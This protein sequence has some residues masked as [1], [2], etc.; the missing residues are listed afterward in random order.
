[1]PYGF[2]AEAHQIFECINLTEYG[3]LNDTKKGYLHIMISMGRVDLNV[4]TQARTVLLET[5]FP[6][7]SAPITNTALLALISKYTGAPPIP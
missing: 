1:M 2:V 4:G 7:A 5:I 6:A 3:A